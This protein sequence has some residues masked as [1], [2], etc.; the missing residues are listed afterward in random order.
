MPTNP[1]ADDLAIAP[2]GLV[3]WTALAGTGNNIIVPLTRVDPSTVANPLL[4]VKL[5]QVEWDVAQC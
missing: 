4:A 3:R 2:S 5:N 1:L